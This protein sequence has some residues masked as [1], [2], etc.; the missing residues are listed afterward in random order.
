MG[1]SNGRE[2]AREKRRAAAWKKWIERGREEFLPGAN[3]TWIPDQHFHL[4]FPAFACLLYFFFS[5]PNLPMLLSRPA[6]LVF[7]PTRHSAFYQW[8]QIQQINLTL[9][10]GH[11]FPHLLTIGSL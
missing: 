7:G 4:P 2:R 9:Y 1:D 5:A 6:D 8:H 10:M 3:L 11:D